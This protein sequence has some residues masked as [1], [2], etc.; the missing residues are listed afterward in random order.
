MNPPITI[1]ILGAD[2]QTGNLGVSAL[3]AG[4]LQC[5]LHRL[6][7]ANIFLLNYGRLPSV[8]TLCIDG[9]VIKVPLV[10][11]RF[12]KKLYLPNNI[13]ILFLLILIRKFVPWKKV[14]HKLV[15][16]N[17]CLREIDKTDVFVSVAGGDSF[18]DIYGFGR[19]LYVALP[20]ILV[21]LA[22]KRLVHVPQTYGPFRRGVAKGIARFILARSEMIYS[23]DFAGQDEIKRLL[24]NKYDPEKT[25]FCYDVGFAVVPRKPQTI[26]IVDSTFEEALERPLVGVNI[27][28]LLL[29]GGYTGKNMF[30]LAVDYERLISSVIE[31]L[32]GKKQAKVLLI[33]HVLSGGESDV[34]AC[35]KVYESLKAK[36]RDRIGVVRGSYDQSEIKDVIGRCEFFIGSR[37][38]ACIAALSQSVPAIS[39]AYSDKFVGVMESILVSSLVMDTRTMTQ[40]EIVDSIDRAYE[41]RHVLRRQLEGK[42]P[43][44]HGALS[45]LFKFL[46]V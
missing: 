43:D 8:S 40:E 19:L 26:S 17:S 9:K 2:F 28:G 3:A 24:G 36:Y 20:Q 39:I 42:L 7:A 31:L 41:E 27:S 11:M 29:A 5:L 23:R 25:K 35:E 6:P 12:S 37:M 22:G 33:A 4:T 32:I 15:G 18:S 30:G 38:H 21:L 16:S 46:E 44:V 10:N 13:A 45:V 34:G 1:G 14:R